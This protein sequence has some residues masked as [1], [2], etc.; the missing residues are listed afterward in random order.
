[1]RLG[2]SVASCG[3]HYAA[4]RHPD[5]D[6]IGSIDIRHH[7]RAAQIAE[8]GKMD[9]LFI[10]DWASIMN[11][12]D[13]RI[14][15]DRE[16]AQLKLEPTLVCAAI[17]AVT[18]LVGMMPTASTTYNHPVTFAR[19]MAAI[20]HISGGRIGWNM[21]TSTNIDEAR[22]FGLAKPLDSN[23]RHARAAEFLEVM[24]ALWDS[25][26]EEG[27]ASRTIDHAGKFFQVRGPLD[28]A[29]PP[30][31]FLPIVT[32]GTSDNAQELAARYADMC[33]GGQPDIES[34]R[35]YYASVKGRLARYGRTPDDMM[36]LPGIQCY[37][38]RTMQEARDKFERMQSSMDPRVGIG[39]LIINQ[40]PDLT[41]LGLDDPV[42][43]V[44]IDHAEE[45]IPG[46]EPKYT[47]ALMKRAA[48]EK[49][50]LRQLFDVVM[51]GFW[52]LGVVGTPTMIADIMEEWFTT[53]AADGFNV[54]PPYMPFAAEDFVELVIPELQR[55]G[56]FRRDYEGRTLRE[57]LGLKRPARRPELRQAGE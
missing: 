7:I 32:A 26:D 45:I 24:R 17:A 52:S 57:N 49:M 11:L 53:G 20:D 12:D 36:M 50:T 39:Q 19:R 47:A 48:E 23:T 5:V 43:A 38:G 35:D 37:I 25:R 2:L 41:G 28:T 56:L 40:F 27:A 21:V 30:Q 6:P 18:K 55:R 9:F 44:E 15:R 34:A 46:H 14:A 31:G 33:Y 42:P 1:M 8:R 3:Y 13:R 51:C 22:N 16:H 10:A 29:R 54:Q 4:W